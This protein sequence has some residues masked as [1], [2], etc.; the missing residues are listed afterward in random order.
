[1]TLQTSVVEIA[2]AA[3]LGA[4]VLG[5]GGR[6]W[7]F[8]VGWVLAGNTNFSISGTFEVIVF[9]A[10]VGLFSGTAYY[11]LLR[12]RIKKPIFEAATIGLGSYLALC[13]L[14]I[15]GKDAIMVYEKAF[16]FPILLGFAILFFLFGA[17]V[18]RFS[19]NDA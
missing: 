6:L 5:A 14:P 8:L 10:L 7:M 19:G 4:V 16:W 17:A 2:K 1:M 18:V 3:L 13:L 12:G 9:G 11:F 15:D